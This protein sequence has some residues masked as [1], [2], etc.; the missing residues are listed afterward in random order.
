MACLNVY[1]K[2]IKQ[3]GLIDSLVDRRAFLHHEDHYKN[4]R[5]VE[6]T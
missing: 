2:T 1:A 5:F 4:H 6:L 3:F